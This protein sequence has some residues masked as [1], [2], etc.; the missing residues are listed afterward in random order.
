[1]PF[2]CSSPSAVSRAVLL[3]GVLAASTCASASALVRVDAGAASGS[4][5]STF[6]V[7]D[8]AQSRSTR[9]V[10]GFS[11]SDAAQRRSGETNAGVVGRSLD[12]GLP[13]AGVVTDDAFVWIDAA[14]GAVAGAIIAALS[15]AGLSLRPKRRS[16]FHPAA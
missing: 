7:S 3:A 6:G 13:T 9:L 16:A 4:P 1:M 11:A 5:P 10:A 8:A 12:R 15:A 2:R 14:I